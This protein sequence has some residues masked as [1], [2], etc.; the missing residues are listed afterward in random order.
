MRYAALDG[1]PLT[2]GQQCQRVCVAI[3]AAIEREGGRFDV[4]RWFGARRDRFEFS[5]YVD[6]WYK[7]QEYAP[8]WGR[9]VE[10][11]LAAY[12]V[13]H[14]QGQ[15]IREI[16]ARDLLLFTKGLPK[17]LTE[18]TKKNVLGVLHKVMSDAVK[19][20][21]LERLPAWPSISTM[22]TEI[23][24]LDPETQAK[25]LNAIPEAHRPVF[26]FI[27]EY[28]CRPGEARALHWD[29]VDFQRETITIRRGFSL[30]TLVE[31]TKT[32]RVRILP[33]TTMIKSLLLS[34]PR[35]SDF[36]FT[37][38]A[39]RPFGRNSLYKIWTKVARS[40]GV[41]IN[42]Y[43][44]T[45]HTKGCGL[46]NAGHGLE[47]IQSLFGHSRSDMTR[48]Y[49]KVTTQTLR[50]VLESGTNYAKAHIVP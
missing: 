30:D 26:Q 1:S 29:C 32:R 50:R 36:V 19:W 15:D 14:F 21:D 13:P 34:L 4:A 18:K 42:L 44:G 3:D 33:M 8:S 48:R 11:Y 2:N 37:N 49:A 16:S 10:H 27:A 17:R 23:K 40:M 38:G 12:L 47:V 46:V 6:D 22:E 31:H 28:G 20:G 24:W 43:Q 39:G 5:N 7:L 35:V 45:R 25:V 9:N 41:D